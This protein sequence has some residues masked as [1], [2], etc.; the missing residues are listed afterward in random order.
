MTGLRE[1]T[2]NKNISTALQRHSITCDT[3]CCI[4]N[5]TTNNKKELRKRRGFHGAGPVE[6]IGD[7]NRAGAGGI[8]NPSK[9]GIIT[10]L[11]LL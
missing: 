5:L 4:P 6:R 7:N 11:C 9:C 1:E 2:V 3:N 10:L 8:I